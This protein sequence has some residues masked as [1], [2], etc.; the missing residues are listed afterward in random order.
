MTDN[1]HPQ[2]NHL[3]AALSADTYSRLQ[4]HLEL[5]SFPLGMVLY[6][7]GDTLH[8]V[9]FPL[10]SIVSLLYVMKNGA[11]AVMPVS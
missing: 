10:D 5:M 6:E 11:S 1:Y 9:Y 2:Q 3:L 8:H 7:S 4:P